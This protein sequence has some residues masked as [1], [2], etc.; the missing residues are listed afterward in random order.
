MVPMV[1]MTTSHGEGK[2]RARLE[3]SLIWSENFIQ[4]RG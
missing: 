1:P 3:C 2:G 4:P